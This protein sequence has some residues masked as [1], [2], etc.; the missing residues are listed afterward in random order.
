VR[1]EY[2]IIFNA[3]IISAF[4][5]VLSVP[6]DK[7][8]DAFIIFLFKQMLTWFLGFMVVQYRLL[9]YPVREFAYA[10]RNSF[11]FEYFIYPAICVVFS[12]WFPKK[13]S[14]AILWY[15][16]FPSWMSTVEYFLEKYTKVIHYIRWEWYYT[17]I[18]LLITFY[19]TRQFY[20]W[21]IRG[22]QKED[23]N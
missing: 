10:A 23:A 18:S 6:R 2:L 20:L 21:F 8:R 4:L 1:I 3:W 22:N 19:L 12:M 5:V 9:E 11:S 14:L 13:R 7:I 17:W 16:L 15:L